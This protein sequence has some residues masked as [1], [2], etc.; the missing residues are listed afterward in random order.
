MYARRVQGDRTATSP[1]AGRSRTSWAL[2][3][4]WRARL[5]PLWRD[6]R[7]PLIICA[8]LAVI[9][10][11]T[12]GFD[13]DGDTGWEAFF[14]S[15]QLFT[16]GAGNV[17]SEAPLVLNIARVLGPLLV[18]VAAI[19]G[20]LLLSREQLRLIGFRLFR[21]NHIVVAGLGE[22]GFRLA[23]HLNELGA[24]VIAI[25]SDPAAEAIEGCHERGISVLI[26]DAGDPDL[27]RAACVHR[28]HHLIAAP[29]TD[30]VAID[31]VA[32]ATEVTGARE[33]EPLRVLARI[34]DRALW[35]ALQARSLIRGD[36]PGVRVELFNL[37]EAAGRLLLET[38]PP[39]T[40]AAAGERQG[41]SVMFV[42]DEA[43]AEILIVNTARLWRN[44][45]AH[46]RSRIE[47]TLAGPQAEAACDRIR[48]RHPTI[49]SVS[50]LDAW[51]VDLAAPELRA[52]RLAR[53]AE[54][55]Y[56]A[57]DDE[58]AGVATALQL[59][60]AAEGADQVVLAVDDERRGAAKIVARDRD[61]LE[62]F[63]ILPLVL[64][65]RFLTS[66]LTETLARAMHDS[67]E[68]DQIA[69]GASGVNVTSWDEID[70][71]ARSSN[72]DFA[73][74]IPGKL[75]E[76]GFVV[77]PEALADAAA[78][79]AVFDQ[80][81][82]GRLEPMAEAEHERWMTERLSCGWVYGDSRVD[83]AKHH[84][85]LVP[86]AQLSEEEKDKDRTAIRDLPVMLAKAGFAIEPAPGYSPDR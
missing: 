33:G 38:F 9:V 13:Q 5:R 49:D 36:A 40:A 16:L 54:A 35:Q 37:Y 24:R 55:I 73:A 68:R 30:G 62:L 2:R 78:S 81:L 64:S 11:G 4:L 34:E 48:G 76:L 19:R 67:Y 75:G 23:A 74:A 83:A 3:R 26:G 59:V 66:G 61:A 8:G 27:L 32:A 46:E 63:A 85:C 72:R 1:F 86:Y 41:P 18:G 14:H 12:I 80:R 43:I 6:L 17:D 44:S 39:F 65:E 52:S 60:A 20:L 84:P 82:D 53:E 69:K 10:L 57:L 50:H 70:D 79:Q 25:E 58:V 22:V 7:A 45:R 29:G 31:V 42:A 77:V 71:D 47:L 15:F 51:Q 21:R 56:V 28:A